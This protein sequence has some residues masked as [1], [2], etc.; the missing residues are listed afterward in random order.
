MNSTL[1]VQLMIMVGTEF[2][3]FHLYWNQQNTRNL[4]G[5]CVDR[6]QSSPL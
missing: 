3:L 2:W 4:K 6:V 1:L 5:V